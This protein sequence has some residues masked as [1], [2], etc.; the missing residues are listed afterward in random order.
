MLYK[1]KSAKNDFRVGQL[2]SNRWQSLKDIIKNKWTVLAKLGLFLVFFSIPLLGHLIITNITVYELNLGLEEGL[3]TAEY[4]SIQIYKVLNTA[5]I[6]TI[7]LLMI[8]AVGLSGA[9]QVLRQLVWQESVFFFYDIKKGIRLNA[10]PTVAAFFLIGLSHFLFQF[11]IR[12]GYFSSDNLLISITI[13]IAI[14]F[15]VMIVLLSIFV[16]FQLTLYQLSIFGL[17]KNAFLLLMKTFSVTFILVLL[18]FLPWMLLLISYTFGFILVLVSLFLFILPLEL[19]ILM[20][21]TYSVF[22][23]YINTTHYPEI[24]KKGVWQDGQH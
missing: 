15:F 11:I 13:A 14:S 6:I 24:Y 1:K 20:E 22:D 2:P 4:A 16:I 12:G 7:F 9:L 23:S 3:I 10:M 21:Y 8:F 5:N 17:Y 19:L 18:I